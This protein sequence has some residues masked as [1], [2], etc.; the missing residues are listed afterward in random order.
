MLRSRGS[1]HNDTRPTDGR[2]ARTEQLLVMPMKPLTDLEW[3][4]GELLSGSECLKAGLDFR[5]E[6]SGLFFPHM[7]FCVP[8]WSKY[9]QQIEL[10]LA[11]NGLHPPKIGQTE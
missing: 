6:I 7:A 8:N 1:R 3:L 4:P 5:Y 9:F 2:S 11:I 10:H